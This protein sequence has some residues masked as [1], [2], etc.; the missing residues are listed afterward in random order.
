MLSSSSPTARICRAVRVAAGQPGRPAADVDAEAAQGDVV[1]V[2]ALMGVADDEQVVAAGRDRV[3]V[4]NLSAR[5]N[6]AVGIRSQEYAASCGLQPLASSRGARPADLPGPGRHAEGARPAADAGLA[7]RGVC[8]SVA[9]GAAAD[10]SDVAEDV[11]LADSLSMA[12]LLV[13]ETLTPTERAVF[14]LRG[15]FDL[16]YDE[17]AEAVG[18]TPAAV[19]QIAHRAPACVAER[20][21]RGVAPAA[22][23]MSIVEP[24]PTGEAAGAAVPTGPR[25]T[26]SRS[27]PLT[28]TTLRLCS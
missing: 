27:T 13:L 19:R 5:A 8:R 21:P 15:V 12:M 17:L 18:K 10:Q 1:V 20:R 6:V 3:G 2:D 22:A 11:E 14:V 23:G 4:M 26:A 9:A 24:S 28:V 25:E 7:A 16:G